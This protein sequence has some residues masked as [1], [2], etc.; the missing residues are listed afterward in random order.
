MDRA[1]AFTL[2]GFIAS[3]VILT[4]VLFALQSI[5][6]TPTT[7]GT[8]D[9]NTRSNIR[10]KANDILQTTANN[11]TK[12]LSW[13]IRYWNGT[14]GEDTW[15][16]ALDDTVG[17]GSQEPPTAFGDMLNETFEKQGET[18]NV[19][20][21]Y[22]SAT[23]WNES[24][25]LR[26]VY[27]GVPSDN[28][29]VTTYTVTLFDNQTLKGFDPPGGGSGTTDCEKQQI[30]NITG[31]STCFYPI[32]DANEPGDQDAGDSPIYNVVE[33]RVVVW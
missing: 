19:I 11:G 27:R 2:E 25:E 8:V 1:Q 10:L 5:V 22:R 17:Y 28:A 32:P 13:L 9:E 29:V 18:Y 4:A 20:V 16:N 7:G 21:E 3:V 15:T 12:D 24:E 6:L 26:M 31:S 23:D 33:V 30:E 14:D